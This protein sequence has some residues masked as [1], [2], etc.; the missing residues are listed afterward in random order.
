MLWKETDELRKFYSL[1]YALKHRIKLATEGFTGKLITH[2]LKKIVDLLSPY[3]IGEKVLDLGSGWGFLEYFL[4]KHIKQYALDISRKAL[5]ISRG[6]YED[7]ERIVS[8]ARMTPFT[9][10]T[11]DKVFC[12]NLVTHLPSMEE[13]LQ[14]IY[15]ITKPGGL[16]VVNFTN[17]FG[18]ATFPRTIF[19]LRVGYY[20][21]HNLFAPI[22]KS[23]SFGGMKKLL[24]KIGFEILG[25]YGWGISV[26]YS[27][28]QIVPKLATKMTDY[29]IRVQDSVPV[30][31]LS[32]ALVFKVEKPKM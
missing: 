9:D 2:N 13:G 14:E 12:I 1:D 5:T 32:N 28:G 20:A 3:E 17:K 25:N 22:D 19:R 29:I 7:A 10:N 27:L 24:E 11:F 4:P 15:R 16:C 26:I 21:K 18:L 30:K 23:Y 6:V 8:D 31:Y